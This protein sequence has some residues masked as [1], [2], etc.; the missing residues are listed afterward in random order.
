MLSIYWSFYPYNWL[1]TDEPIQVQQ[2]LQKQ[3]QSQPQ[4]AQGKQQESGYS[5]E[6]DTISQVSISSIP[7]DD[8][9]DPTS[10]NISSATTTTTNASDVRMTT[11]EPGTK[12]TVEQNGKWSSNDINDCLISKLLKDYWT[13]EKY[14]P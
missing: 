12:I 4:D 7:E 14:S 3:Q 9:S 2:R 6:P 13:I 5:N 10:A 1:D 8:K 11:E